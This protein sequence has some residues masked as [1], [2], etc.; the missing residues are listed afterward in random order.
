MT[1]RL[2]V[3]GLANSPHLH[4]W[5]RAVVDADISI[6][7]FPALQGQG[8][9]G[10]DTVPMAELQEDLP[11]GIHCLDARDV[12]GDDS[13]AIDR[14][15]RFQPLTHQFVPVG[16][17]A[18]ADRLAEAVT[19]FR[20]DLLHSMESQIAG[21]IVAEL[22]RRQPRSL[23]WFH[24]TWGSDLALYGSLPDH[25]IRLRAMFRGVDFHLADCRN[26]LGL[27]RKLGYIGPELPVLPSSCGIDVAQLTARPSLPPSQRR[28]ILVKGYQNWAG[29]NLSA[30]SALMLI[31]KEVEP[32][33][34]VI[35]NADAALRE[36]A[37][38][39]ANRTALKVTAL[40]RLP[41]PE[42][43]LTELARSRLLVSLS[44]SDGLPTMMLEA[45]ALGAFPIQSGAGCGC[46]WFEDGVTGFSVPVNDT[47]A[48]ADAI[49]RALRDDRMVDAAATRNLA[50][51]SERWG[52]ATNAAIAR[53]V[54]R[55]GMEGR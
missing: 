11:P 22:W 2:L 3:I 52:A 31:A 45:M 13:A 14:D 36:W 41:E 46:D 54:Y 47:A 1:T 15:W 23:P 33:E 5:V 32:Y 26:D 29:R 34:I 18:A 12:R 39:M 43:V 27:A 44:I 40:P 4:R 17:L 37:G 55:R 8:W 51:V 25:E 53:A 48:V 16:A 21:Y 49:S 28:Q 38:I 19:R 50:T 24:S 30:L 6:L 20:P 9:D 35:P 42:A 10:V 7:V